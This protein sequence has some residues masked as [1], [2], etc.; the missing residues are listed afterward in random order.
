MFQSCRVLGVGLERDGPALLPARF[1]IG[2]DV[3]H[4]AQCVGEAGERGP[5]PVTARGRHAMMCPCTFDVAPPS[6][7][8]VAVSPVLELTL[9]IQN[10][11]ENSRLRFRHFA[12]IF[13]KTL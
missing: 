9:E 3:D 4:E 12:A 8:A 1:G 5:P 11:A 10:A 13:Q 2:Q 6:W 7:L